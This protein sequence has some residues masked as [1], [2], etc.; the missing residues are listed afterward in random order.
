MC[1]PDQ[2][3]MYGYKISVT[4]NRFTDAVLQYVAIAIYL[5]VF[6][7]LIFNRYGTQQ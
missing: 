4:K 2:I 5:V 1:P 6:E 3:R 7:D